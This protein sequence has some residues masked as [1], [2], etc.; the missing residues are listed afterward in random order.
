MSALPPTADIASSERHVRSVIAFYAT[1]LCRSIARELLY[2]VEDASRQM[3]IVMMATGGV[4]GYYG[5]RLA[6]ADE[7][8]HFI[9]RGA[10]LAALRTNGLKLISANGDIHLRSVQATDDPAMI[11][12][13][14]IVI[15]AV[16]QYDTETAAA[17]LLQW[18]Q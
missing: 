2:A 18:R 1:S 3:K 9:A 7:D 16:K 17:P 4:G 13:A 10:H 11:G 15:F 12:T 8:V 14:D 5:A 6:A